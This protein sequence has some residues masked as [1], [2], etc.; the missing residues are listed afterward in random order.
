[1]WP[2]SLFLI[3]QNEKLKR[4]FFK[5]IRLIENWMANLTNNSVSNSQWFLSF[6]SNKFNKKT[7]AN[8]ELN[9]GPITC[10]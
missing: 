8:F 2:T 10:K 1:M 7:A 6:L 9:E 5:Q 4:R 3:I